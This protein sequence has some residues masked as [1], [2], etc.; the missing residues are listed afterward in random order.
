MAE[1]ILRGAGF[2]LSASVVTIFKM[3]KGFIAGIVQG[4]SRGRENG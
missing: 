3:I 1:K 4:I 2:V